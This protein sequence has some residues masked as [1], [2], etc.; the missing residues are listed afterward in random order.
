MENHDLKALYE[1]FFQLKSFNS[2]FQV[3]CEKLI[4]FSKFLR[5]EILKK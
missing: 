4:I 3:F 2:D 1:K 5:Y